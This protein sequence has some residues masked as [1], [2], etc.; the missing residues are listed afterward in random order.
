M[1]WHEMSAKGKL[2]FFLVLSQLILSQVC[3]KFYQITILY[4]KT[5]FSLPDNALQASH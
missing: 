1:E 3:N 5:K 2:E 4:H